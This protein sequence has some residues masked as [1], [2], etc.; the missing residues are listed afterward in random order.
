MNI[1]IKYDELKTK[2]IS[3]LVKGDTFEYENDI[4]I[5]LQNIYNDRRQSFNLTRNIVDYL[6]DNKIVHPVTINATVEY[7]RAD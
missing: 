1:K 4:Y 5:C 7:E 3:E 6:E 2:R